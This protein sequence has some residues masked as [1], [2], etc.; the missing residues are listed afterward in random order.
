MKKT[1]IFPLLIMS[2]ASFS[3]MAADQVTS[4]VKGTGVNACLTTVSDLETF[5]ADDVNYGSWA[6][7]AKEGPD[8]QLVNTTLELTYSDESVLVDF[9]V[10]PTIDGH[11]SYSYTRTFYNAKSCMATT[12][13][14]FMKGATYKTD[15]NKNIAAF[16][17]PRGAKLLLMSVGSGCLVQKKEIGFRHNKQGS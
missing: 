4:Y 16:E 8:E 12:Q 3:A 13:E 6:F 7:V 15:I 1:L 17:D 5:F 2:S 14:S 11:C 9:T 10:A